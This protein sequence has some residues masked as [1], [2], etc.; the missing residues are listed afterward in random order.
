[1]SSEGAGNR[2]GSPRP[3]PDN[4]SVRPGSAAPGDGSPPDATAVANEE[5]AGADEAQSGDSI[6][7]ELESIQIGQGTVNLKGEA[8]VL[9]A[10][11]L[12]EQHLAAH[13]CFQNV[14]LEGT[15][16]ITFE[17]HRG[18]YN[19]RIS[20]DLECQAEGKR[21]RQKGAR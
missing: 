21:N 4:G 18:W 5:G 13:R 19:F 16:K 7:L 20:F 10:S 9:E 11:T 3:G 17:R 1:M 8:S 15:D 6:L 12:L 14:V 2:G